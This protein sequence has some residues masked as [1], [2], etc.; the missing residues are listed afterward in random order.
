MLTHLPVTDSFCFLA[1][2]VTILIDADHPKEFDGDHHRDGDCPKDG[3]LPRDVYCP[4]DE[5]SLMDGYYTIQARRPMG[6]IRDN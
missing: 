1:M 3:N 6:F 5:D 4:L 2:D